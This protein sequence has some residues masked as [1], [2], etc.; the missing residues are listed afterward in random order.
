MQNKYT[1]FLKEK[2]IS[3]KERRIEGLIFTG[4]G[5]DFIAEVGK[6]T[7]FD[8]S[9]ILD[10]IINHLLVKKGVDW[11]SPILGEYMGIY[12]HSLASFSLFWD[13]KSKKFASHGVS[14]QSIDNPLIGLVAHIRTDNEYQGLGLGTLMTEEVTDA[15][16]KNNAKFVVLAT[17]DKIHRL[18]SGEKT[19]YTLYSKIGYSILAEKKLAD[20]VDWLMIINQEIFNDCQKEKKMNKGRFP[21]HVSNDV[22]KKQQ[23]LA[24][25]IKR[26]F[27]SKKRNLKLQKVTDG[28]MAGLFMLIALSPENDFR[29]KLDSWDIHQ[30][31]EFERTFVVNIRPAILDQDRIEDATLVLRDEKGFILAVCAA[32]QVYPFSR[33]TMK[34]DFYCFPEFLEKNKEEIL[35]LIDE[36][37]KRIKEDLN[38]P[39]T[40]ILSFSGIDRAKIS[41]FKALGFKKAGNKYQYY[42]QEGTLSYETSEFSRVL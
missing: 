6:K 1:I 36:T 12:K 26:D 27:G 4:C 15:A 33:N 22:K 39:K 9:V 7:G 31:P 28:D 19:A 37:M 10:Y 35:N 34:I 18:E 42:N 23:I 14:F 8:G 20:T 29:I 25:K 16:F 24:D 41:I 2:I 5:A 3:R 21:K 40:C 30:G 13:K 32:K 17:D 38:A 11:N